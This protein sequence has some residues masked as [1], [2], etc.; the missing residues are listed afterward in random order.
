VTL[1]RANSR[2]LVLGACLLVPRTPQANFI[3]WGGIAGGIFFHEFSHLHL[4]PALAGSWVL[5]IMGLML[6]VYGLYLV[7]P[8]TYDSDTAMESEAAKNNDSL[9]LRDA[10]KLPPVPAAS[11]LVVSAS[12]TLD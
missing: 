10:Q 3:V 4:G 12:S 1:L 2:V 5:Y 9:D 6:V 8:K 11:T 7:R